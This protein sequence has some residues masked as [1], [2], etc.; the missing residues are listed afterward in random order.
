MYDIIVIGAGHAGVEAALAATRLGSKTLL[1]TI[2]LDSVAMLA[3]NPSIG[4]TGKGH[5]VREIDALGGQMGLLA[6]SV[7][8][9]SKMLNKA[10]GPAV[11]SLRI[12]ADKYQYHDT[13]KRLLEEE[14][15]LTLRQAEVEALT[16]KDGRLSGVMA[17]GGLHFEAKSVIIAS[18]TYLRSKVFIGHEVIDIG[19]AGLKNTKKLSAQLEELGFELM[20][21][22]TGTPARIH[23]D[24]LDY[25]E[26]T[27][28]PGDE[29]IVPFS[30]MNDKLEIDQIDCYL[31]YSNLTTHQLIQDNIEHSAMYSGNIEGTGARY[32]PSIEDKIT[33]FADKDRHQ[34]FLEPE[35]L[36]TKELYVQG[37]SSSLPESVQEAFLKTMDGMKAVEVLRPGYAIE[38][39]C[40]NP[41]QL[42]LS[43]ESKL[44]EH[45]F[46]AGQVNGS[47]GYEEAA[48]QG[49]MAGINAHRKLQDEEPIV[50]KRDQAYIGVLIDDLVTK[51]ADEPFRMMTS[52]CEYRLV[53]RQD[54][55]DI[56]LT[57]IGREVGL[58]SDERWERFQAKQAI[59]EAELQ[60]IETTN[61]KMDQINPLLESIGETPVNENVSIKNLLKRS[62][63]DYAL[64]GPID[65][66][67]GDIPPEV[68]SGIEVEVKYKGY[69]D[70]QLK[71][72]ERFQSLESK[73]IPE[74][75]DYHSISGLR[76]EA[77]QKLA[78]RRP[79]NLG[80]ASRISGVNPADLSVLLIYLETKR[81]V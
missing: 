45:L 4:G 33:R 69:I 62:K 80:Q 25:S 21:F 2:N 26:L 14:P 46:F 57:P 27:L 77:R 40:I 22:K 76:I 13:T 52:R 74:D 11:H 38:Y 53:L 65:Q 23:A 16:F 55:A 5:L 78:D 49:L 50:L 75:I 34:F 56:R 24:S 58:V 19:P 36:K 64:L 79:E 6:D 35:G 59:R 67:R 9:Q 37:M 3:C 28:H 60:R 44:V 66:T 29:E 68:L 42:K 39:D 47:S 20:R 17:R 1:L 72:I 70:K 15:G 63:V 48:A 41:N 18:G 32:C 61:L 71:Q 81:R 43:L 51:G 12:Q 54:N 30:F 10:K 31:G 73:L 8:L 7:T